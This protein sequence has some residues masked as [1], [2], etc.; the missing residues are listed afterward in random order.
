MFKLIDSA[1]RSSRP[2]FA[3]L[4]CGVLLSCS[5]GIIPPD[6]PAAPAALEVAS[7][8]PQPG[9][10]GE[11]LPEPVVVRVLDREGRGLPQVTVTFSVTAGGGSIVEMGLTDQEGYARTVWVLG[12]EGEQEATAR[13][14]GLSPSR[15]HARIVPA[16]ATARPMLGMVGGYITSSVS[17]L[18]SLLPQNQHIASYIQARLALLRTPGLAGDIIEGGRYAEGSIASRSGASVPVTAVFPVEAMR[19]E[20]IQSVRFAESAMPVVEAFLGT[21]FPTQTV[22]IWHGFI[23]GNLGGGGTLN[24]EDRATYEARTPATRL[25]YDAIIVHELS[26]S[27]V[28]NESLT[29]FLEL[30]GYNVLRTGSADVATWTFTRGWIPGSAANENVHALLDVYRLIGPAAMAS[31]YRAVLPL[32]PAYGQPLSAAAQQAFVDAA[33]A[34]AKAEVAAKMARIQS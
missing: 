12:G 31:A 24:M 4:A 11:R 2:L 29:Q 33:P 19:A 23:L 15:L 17:Y 13:V 27:Y 7:R 20:A 21:S 25:P 9:V 16:S 32:R 26:H 28:A 14:E 10:A 30:Y 22:H 5:D 18:E 1:R 6:D 8:D 34:A 3:A